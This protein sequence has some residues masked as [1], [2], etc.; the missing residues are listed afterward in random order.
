MTTKPEYENAVGRPRLPDPLTVQ[1]AFRAAA[2]VREEFLAWLA[3]ENTLRIVPMSE[4]DALR[5]L[6]A[7]AARARPSL[8]DLNRVPPGPPVSD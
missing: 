7:W 8:D 4:A 2:K 5:V 1:I 3:H 6:V